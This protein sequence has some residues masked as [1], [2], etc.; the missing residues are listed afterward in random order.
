MKNYHLTFLIAAALGISACQNA[1]RNNR[2][3][4]ATTNTDTISDTTSRAQVYTADVDLKGDEKAFII[5]AYATGMTEIETA[6]IA[7]IRTANAK[8]KEF[9]SMMVKD[10]T[11]ANADL[12][13]LA[14]GKG[15]TIPSTLSETQLKHIKQMQELTGRSF[16]IHYINMMVTDH[17]AAE[18]LFGHATSYK[19]ENLKNFILNTLPV[20][21]QHSKM[22][23]KIGKDLN[24]SNAGNGDDLSNANPDSLS[25]KH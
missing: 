12:A 3:E 13:K 15:I 16:D 7:V 8:I 25:Q 17:Q 11:K 21:Q 10:H 23:T 6:K 24:I 9:A 1:D 5:Q 19:D 18:E 4:A 14:K 2:D 20:I 22:I